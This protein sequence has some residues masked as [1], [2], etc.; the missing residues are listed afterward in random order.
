M[1]N[2]KS[3][4][5]FMPVSCQLLVGMSCQTHAAI[6]MR[7]F[8]VQQIT[9]LWFIE[10]SHVRVILYSKT[11]HST[12][13]VSTTLCVKLQNKVTNSKAVIKP[14]LVSS[15][16]LNQFLQIWADS[17]A[18]LPF[19]IQNSLLLDGSQKNQQANL[20][21]NSGAVKLQLYSKRPDFPTAPN[22]PYR[23]KLQKDFQCQNNFAA[24]AK[25]NHPTESKIP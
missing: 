13:P 8:K 25:L 5:K 12:I 3:L 10:Q 11:S 7:S 4:T 18:S 9:S 2:R 1:L 6:H 19:R 21:C 17:L 23:L 16:L 24:H 22:L 20:R 14:F 15:F